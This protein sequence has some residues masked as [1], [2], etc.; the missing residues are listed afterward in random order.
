MTEEVLGEILTEV[1]KVSIEAVQEVEHVMTLL[2]WKNVLRD[3]H[4][5]IGIRGSFDMHWPGRGS[6]VSY[7]SD[8]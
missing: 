1:A 6:G 3:S 8:S 7:N 4:G 2:E 5:N